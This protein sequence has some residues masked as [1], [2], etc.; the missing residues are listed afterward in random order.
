MPFYEI[1]TAGE[2]AKRLVKAASAKSAIAHCLD[3]SRYTARTIK[4]VEEA[5]PLFEAGVRVEHAVGPAAAQQE[6]K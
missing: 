3:P 1:T 2:D 4:T 6:E 5:V